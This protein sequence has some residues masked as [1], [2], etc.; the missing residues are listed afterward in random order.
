MK[1]VCLFAAYYTSSQIPYYIRVYITEL[2]KHFDD[3]ILLPGDRELNQADREFLANNKLQVMHTETGGYDF[4]LWYRALAR[5]DLGNVDRLA[6]INDSCVLF[7]PLD[8]FMQWSRSVEARVKGMTISDA[9]APHLQSYFLIFDKEALGHVTDY[10][11]HH[12]TY[13]SISDVIKNYEIGLSVYLSE[14]GLKLAAYMDNEGYHGEF[15]PYYRCI[16]YHLANGIPLI[17]KKILFG[18]YRTDELPNLARMGFDVSATYYV[19]RIKEHHNQLII[20]LD[21]LIQENPSQLGYLQRFGFNLRKLMI[22]LARPIYR[23]LKG[24]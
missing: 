7:A 14:K 22:K 20:D 13:H 19:N 6:L 9:V 8:K 3:V 15:S 12:K 17:K 21:R 10:F 4:G 23:R 16:N 1:A 2:R 18:S 11:N 5:L 24:A